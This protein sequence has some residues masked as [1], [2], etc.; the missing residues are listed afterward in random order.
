VY[1]CGE[2]LQRLDDTI[3]DIHDHVLASRSGN[4]S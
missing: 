1:A 3:R 2:A 4:P